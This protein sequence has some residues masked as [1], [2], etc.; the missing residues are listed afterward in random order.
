MAPS[1]ASEAGGHRVCLFVHC[2]LHTAAGST[3]QI[4][5]GVLPSL[6]EIVAEP[7]T[8]SVAIENTCRFHQ[9]LRPAAQGLAHMRRPSAT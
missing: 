9:R 5:R 7:S 8:G 6:S 2:P 1:Q 4:N 3:S